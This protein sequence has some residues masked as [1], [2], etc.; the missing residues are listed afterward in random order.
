[1]CTHPCSSTE[2]RYLR[3]M[4]FGLAKTRPAGL[5]FYLRP[6]LLLVFLSSGGAARKRD[7]HCLLFSP[8][9]LVA[10]FGAGEKRSQDSF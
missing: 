8:A 10:E 1:M 9:A 3:P 4:G 7:F 5:G 2:A 6:V